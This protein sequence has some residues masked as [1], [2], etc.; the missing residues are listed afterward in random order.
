MHLRHELISYQEELIDYAVHFYTLRTKYHPIM[1]SC[2]K[3]FGFLIDSV[4][5]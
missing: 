5:C 1:V 3:E 4:I 2:S